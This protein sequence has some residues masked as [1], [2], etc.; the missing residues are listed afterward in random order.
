MIM[1][2][3]YGISVDVFSQLARLGVTRV[4]LHAKTGDLKSQLKTWAVRG[5]VKDYGSGEQVFLSTEFMEGR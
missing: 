5:N 4:I 3:G 1:E 2:H